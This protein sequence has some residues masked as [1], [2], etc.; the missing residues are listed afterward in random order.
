[1]LLCG[2]P[3]PASNVSGIATSSTF[4]TFS[5]IPPGSESNITLAAQYGSASSNELMV[6]ATTMSESEQTISVHVTCA[7]MT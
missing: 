7:T 4:S 5:N 6:N 2:D 3:L 1:M